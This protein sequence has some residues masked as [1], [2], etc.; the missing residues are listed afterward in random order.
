MGKWRMEGRVGLQGTD[1]CVQ[2]WVS[3]RRTGMGKYIWVA[4]A[5]DRKTAELIET[6]PGLLA[7]LEDLLDA[8][9]HWEDQDD[10]VLQNARAAVAKAK[11]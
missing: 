6:A 9:E 3:N 2:E 5:R 1:Y 10:P 11:G 4:D 7:A 8:C